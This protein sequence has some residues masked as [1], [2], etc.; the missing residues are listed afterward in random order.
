MADERAGGAGSVFLVFNKRG[1]VAEGHYDESAAHD[2]ARA[3]EGV[4][5][6]LP[7]VGDYRNSGAEPADP[8]DEV[9][10][11][12]DLLGCIWLYVNWRYVTKQLTTEQREMWADAVDG[13]GEP[14][15]GKA[16]RW[17]RD[18]YIEEQG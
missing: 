9:T 2:T 12:R 3:I 16:E 15:T 10:R 18:N 8:Q 17:W 7:I 6:E 13:F 11:L 1:M 14:E 4:V 5:A